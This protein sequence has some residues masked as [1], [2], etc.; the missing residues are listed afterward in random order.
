MKM[1]C[2]VSKVSTKYINTMFLHN[3]KSFKPFKGR[4]ISSFSKYLP[5]FV[6]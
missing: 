2:L 3:M 6:Y 5:Y 4:N 1:H